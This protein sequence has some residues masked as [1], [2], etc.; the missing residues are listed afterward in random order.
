MNELNLVNELLTLSEHMS[1]P[2]V[3]TGVRVTRSLVLRECFCRSLFLLLPFFFWPLCCLF[4]HIYRFWL[5]LWYLQTLLSVIIVKHASKDWIIHT[6]V[7]Y[8]EKKGCTLMV[9]NSTSINKTINR[10]SPYLTE[11]I[12]GIPSHV[13]RRD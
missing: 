12:K 7:M 10:P 2:P 11:Y 4:F 8:Y 5:P 1:S 6:K 3:F 9:N 13:T